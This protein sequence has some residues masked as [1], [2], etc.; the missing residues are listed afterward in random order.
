MHSSVA[1]GGAVAFELSEMT[2]SQEILLVEAT[3]RGA[4]RFFRAAVQMLEMQLDAL[5]ILKIRDEIM[6]GSQRRLLPAAQAA[7]IGEFAMLRAAILIALLL[8]AYGY[9]QSSHHHHAGAK[10][11][12]SAATTPTQ[13]GQGAFAA[14]QEIVEILEAD[15]RSDWSKVNIGA[16]RQ[17]LIDMD[18]ETLHAEVQSTPIEGGIRFSVTGDG[19]VRQSIQRMVSA[20]AAIM[21]GVGGW[22]ISATETEGGATLT[23]TTPAKDLKKLQARGFIGVMT[24]GMHHQEHHLMIAQGDHPHG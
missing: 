17:H 2:A 16:L 18:D 14:I 23:V 21:N 13:P 19:P 8:P 10:A 4:D 9:A 6:G 15:P 22:K 5:R 11:N 3:R 7:Q 12:Q 24:N 1:I 20:H